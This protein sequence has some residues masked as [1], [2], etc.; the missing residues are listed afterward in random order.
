MTNHLFVY[1]SL[2]PQ[3]T[4]GFGDAE[5]TR[6]GSE[7]TVFG[8]ATLKGRL[9]DL[10]DY[11]G[12]MLPAAASEA[13][14]VHGTLLHLAAPGRTLAW[15]DPFEDTYARLTTTATAAG[16]QDFKT[17]VYVMQRIPAGAVEI[18]S[19]LWHARSR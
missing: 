2:M 11:P 12:L 6:L 14:T 10:G 3:L 18:P 4:G 5:R 1:G 8:P 19:G 13:G 7:S 17:W 9:Y 15:L 16:G